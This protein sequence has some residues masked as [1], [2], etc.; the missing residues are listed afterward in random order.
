[1]AHFDTLTGLANRNLFKERVEET[2]VRYRQHGGGFAVVLLDLDKFK[3]VNDTLGHQ[4]GDLLL[5]GVANRIKATIRDV[6]FAA[7]LGGDE[8]A[9]LVETGKGGLRERSEALAARLIEAVSAPYAIDGHPV[10]VGCS[11]GIALIPQH[12]ERIDEVLRNAD[13]ALYKSKSAGRNCFHI[14]STKMKAEADQRSALEI[15]LREA[16]WGDQLDVHYQPV[17][18]LDTGRVVSVEALAR[19]NHKTKGPIPPSEFIPVAEEAGLIVELG[20]W[21][22]LKACHDAMQMPKDIKVAVNLSPVQFAKSNVVEAAT[23][24]TA[25]SGLAKERLELEITEGVLLEESEQNLAT[26][27]QLKDIGISI[28][29]DDF[30]VGFS[31]LA[32][33]TVFPFDKVKIDKSFIERLDRP[34]TSAVIASIVQLT[35]SLNRSTVAEGIET[36]EQLDRVRSLGL[37]FGQGFLFSKP[38]PASELKFESMNKG[39]KSRAA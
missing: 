8:F 20:N 37:K 12:G 2:L 39:S 36:Q 31:S 14:Y 22:M 9:V 28:A 35:T 19:W 38:V 34:E 4:S 6:N 3:G 26:L 27:R 33:L 30:G 13:L 16:I 15:D 10:V 32:Y 18:E 5:Q 24:A 7:R 29:L 25:E 23:F 1:L 11:I 21:I 17:I